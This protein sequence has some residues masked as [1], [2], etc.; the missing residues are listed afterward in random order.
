VRVAEC[1]EF[2]WE[3][4]KRYIG[5]LI[6]TTL[7]L[8]LAFAAVSFVAQ[9]AFRGSGFAV[10][11]LTAGL[12]AAGLA[13]V[14]RNAARGQAPTVHDAIAPCRDRPGDHLI[15]GLALNCG[16][17]LLGVGW[18]V[19]AFLFMFAPLL[20]IDGADFKQALVGSKDVVLAK[21]GELV[22]LYFV[23]LVFN[24]IGAML[25]F[26]GLL[27]TLPMTALALVKAYEQL[28]TTVLPRGA[29]EPPV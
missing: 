4:F 17:L 18:L 27:V 2:A 8:L 23:L 28:G 5:E 26:V 11:L 22:G 25:M 13:N 15:I 7:V 20:A 14:A 21:P 16:V 24:A 9:V 19:T 29:A 10:N 12:V 6:V 3:T 1:F